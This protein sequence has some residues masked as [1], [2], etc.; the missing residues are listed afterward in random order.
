M[1]VPSI[2]IRSAVWK[3]EG[4][5]SLSLPT[6]A[7]PEF[8]IWLRVS[9]TPFQASASCKLFLSYTPKLVLFQDFH[10]KST[11][12]E[13]VMVLGGESWAY[14]GNIEERF[15]VAVMPTRSTKTVDILHHKTSGPSGTSTNQSFWSHPISASC[16]LLPRPPLSLLSSLLPRILKISNSVFLTYYS[17][18]C[19]PK[20]LGCSDR[21]AFCLPNLTLFRMQ[22]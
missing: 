18:I 4:L 10:T 9:G 6:S 5:C 11:H 13:T 3:G 14:E 8:S 19:K 22:F 7:L 21:K 1:D 12:T 20:L 15:S 16:S 17:Q 2:Y